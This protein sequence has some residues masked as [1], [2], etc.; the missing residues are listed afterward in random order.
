MRW[1][2]V[3]G[4]AE[5]RRSLDSVTEGSPLACGK[6]WLLSKGH[7]HVKNEKK[8]VTRKGFVRRERD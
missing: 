5:R 7:A 8:I 3:L 4:G 1:R 6:E 2:E